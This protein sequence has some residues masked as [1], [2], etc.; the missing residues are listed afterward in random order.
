MKKIKPTYIQTMSALMLLIFILSL[1]PVFYASFFV[2]PIGDDFCFS[3]SVHSAISSGGG[4]LEG[5]KQAFSVVVNNYFSWQGTYA[6]IFLFAF[7]PAVFSPDMYFI[8]TIVMVFSLSLATFFLIDT[9]LVKCLKAERAYSVLISCAVLFCTIQFLISIPEGLFVWNG[10][11]YYTFFYALSLYLFSLL[12]RMLTVGKKKRHIYFGIAIFLAFLIGG[13]N[14]STALFTSCIMVVALF[15]LT[16]QRVDKLWQYYLVF[17]IL[18]LCFAISFVAPGNA[19]RAETMKDAYGPVKAIVASVLQFFLYIGEWTKLPQIILFIFVSPFLYSIACRTEFDFKY[20]LLVL[21]FT[22]LCFSTQLTPAFYGMG[23][24]GVGRQVN[25]YYYSYY[26][27]ILFNI[28]YLSGYAARKNIINIDTSLVSNA[29]HLLPTVIILAALFISGCIGVGLDN[30]TSVKVWNAISSGEAW[31]YEQEYIELME[32][33]QNGEDNLHEV[34]TCP[35]NV[36]FRPL[37]DRDYVASAVAQY[38]GVDH[39]NIIPFE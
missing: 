39:F 11:V 15:F 37:V 34:Y 3:A 33:I 16:R 9:I 19:V 10:S 30:M 31:Q 14:Y 7:Q 26:L 12:L 2:H 6:A 21:I 13:G 35:A 23:G 25:I 36:F 20:P 24:P 22:F 4:L 1:I 29:K 27:L 18:I 8:T 28:F 38:Y 5:L 17:F 32:R